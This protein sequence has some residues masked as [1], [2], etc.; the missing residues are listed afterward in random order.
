MKV[1]L[2]LFALLALLAGCKK[3]E[4]SASEQLAHDIQVIDE[5]LS[6]HSIT[7]QQDPSGL[8]YVVTTPG[9]G[10]IP[11]LANT[12]TV[13]YVGKL[14]SDGSVFDQSTSPVSFK[15]SQLISGWQI[16]FQLLKKGSKATLYVPSGLGYGTSGSGP[17]PS[18][19]NLIFDVSLIDVK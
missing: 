12:I 14:L 19:A 3:E 1:R 6:A 11:N 5:Y 16:G 9:T 15:L 10:Q 8:R 2:F 18:N 13:T 7:A 17:I 4:L